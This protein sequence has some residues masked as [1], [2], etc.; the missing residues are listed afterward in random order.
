[1]QII[2]LTF[3]HAG[4]KHSL[5]SI[6]RSATSARSQPCRN[7]GF[8]SPAQ[9]YDPSRHV[10]DPDNYH[11]AFDRA[12]NSPEEFWAEQAQGVHWFRTWDKVLDPTNIISPKWYVIKKLLIIMSEQNNVYNLSCFAM[13]M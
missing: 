1:M 9:N 2:S 5:L 13:I 4:T 6:A 11:R 3:I 12:K 10:V 8:L 7:E